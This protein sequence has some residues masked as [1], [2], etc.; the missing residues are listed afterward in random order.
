MVLGGGGAI[1]SRYAARGRARAGA[2]AVLRAGTNDEQLDHRG[3][4]ASHRVDLADLNR[5]L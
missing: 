1:G 3:R 5:S 2:H 4:V